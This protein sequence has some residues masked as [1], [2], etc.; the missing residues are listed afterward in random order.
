MTENSQP[1]PFPPAARHAIAAGQSIVVRYEDGSAS[2]PETQIDAE[3]IE[4]AWSVLSAQYP[5]AQVVGVEPKD[6]WHTRKQRGEQDPPEVQLAVDRGWAMEVEGDLEFLP[7]DLETVGK[8]LR[9]DEVREFWET[10]APDFL[11]ISVMLMG[12]EARV[13]GND[14]GKTR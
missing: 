12:D 2:S 9:P 7:G 5:T 13:M 4:G 10:E 3:H 14:R 8:A 11:N 6:F 1:K